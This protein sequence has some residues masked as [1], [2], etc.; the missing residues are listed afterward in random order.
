MELSSTRE[1]IGCVA[2][3]SFLTFLESEGSLPHSQELSNCPYPELDQSN[4]HQAIPP[5]QNHSTNDT[6]LNNSSVSDTIYFQFA[7]RNRG[8]VDKK[9]E[10]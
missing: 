4:P 8:V 9:N 7:K 5:L 10:K 3:H 1:P 6:L 2:T